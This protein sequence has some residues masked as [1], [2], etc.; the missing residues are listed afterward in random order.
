MEWLR[1][2][3]F[4]TECS[5]QDADAAQHRYNLLVKRFLANGTTTA[6]YFGTL[7]LKPNQ[8][9]VD[10]IVKL[11]QRAVVGKASSAC[12]LQQDTQRSEQQLSR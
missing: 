11:G 3:T 1:K 7:H 12:C 6:T 2:Y 10:S 5:Y 4:P 8:V 9:L